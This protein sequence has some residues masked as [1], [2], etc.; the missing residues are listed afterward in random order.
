MRNYSNKILLLSIIGLCLIGYGIFKLFYIDDDV[1]PIKVE[2]YGIT[3]SPEKLSVERHLKQGDLVAESGYTNI[4][5]FDLTIQT[6]DVFA[7]N[8]PII[9][10]SKIKVKDSSKIA[11]IGFLLNPKSIDV[12]QMT[13]DQ[14]TLFM[15]NNLQNIAGYKQDVIDSSI[16]E[17]VNAE[18]MFFAPTDNLSYMLFIQAKNGNMER[19]LPTDTLFSVGP[20]SEKLQNDVNRLTIEQIKQSD[21]YTHAQIKNNHA[22]EGLTWILLGWLPIE[23]A[24]SLNRKTTI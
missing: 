12:S 11:Q 4:D 10:N 24:I 5:T 6:S 19:F 9:I 17:I 20:Y 13:D 18:M 21:T 15:N 2:K 22:V 23:L 1:E 14:M 16:Y 8:N 7:V 3:T